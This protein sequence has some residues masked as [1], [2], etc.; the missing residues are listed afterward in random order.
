MLSFFLTFAL[1][2]IPILIHRIDTRRKGLVTGM[3]L[4]LFFWGNLTPALSLVPLGAALFLFWENR[5]NLSAVRQVPFVKNPALP[6]FVVFLLSMTIFCAFG[7]AFSDY[8]SYIGVSPEYLS[9]GEQLKAAACLI[10]PLLTGSRCDRKG[11]FSTAILLT[12]LAELSV[13]ITSSGNT[14]QA[15][16]LTGT[17]IVHICI[18]GFFVLM[19]V[20]A[21]AFFGETLFYRMY[22]FIALT[23]ALAWT[24]ARLLY[25]NGW[26]SAYN[27]GD[28]LIGLLF[29][30]VLSATFIC[31][32]W[33][34][35]F[36]LLS[37][38]GV[39]KQAAEQK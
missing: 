23:A 15:L 27:P 2:A 12:L 29:L 11:P 39:Q 4:S 21:S 10:G 6:M 38:H 37:Q 30:T 5:P 35:R 16:F 22:P 28:F 9:I 7:T 8:G 24:A 13:F 18:S 26:V 3:F 36:V 17:F 25:L 20:I 31:I 32:A 34:R 19:P 1:L 14:H 33:K